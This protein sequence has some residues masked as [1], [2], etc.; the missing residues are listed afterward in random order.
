MISSRADDGSSHA[1]HRHHAVEG[2]AFIGH[3][4]VPELQLQMPKFQGPTGKTSR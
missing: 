1:S 2:P 4:Q 3:Q